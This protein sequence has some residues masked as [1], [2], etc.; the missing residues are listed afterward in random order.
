MKG[1]VVLVLAPHTDDGELGCGGTITKL[2]ED[3]NKV[4]YAAFSTAEESVPEGI[5][6][7][8]LKDEVKEATNALGIK[9]ENIILFNYQVRR[10]N[11]LR[12]NILED[13]ISLKKSI[14]PN[15]V[16]I[17]SM[18]DIHQDHSVVSDEGIRAFKNC[19]VL[20]YELPWNNSVFKT[21]AFVKLEKKHIVTKIKSLQ[22]YNSQ[23]IRPYMDENFINSLAQVRGLQ[24]GCKFAE[25]FEVIRWII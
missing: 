11:E 18:H 2:I 13:I 6:K 22:Y 10:F 14:E 12:Q 9:S 16:F 21:Q 19:T 3:G 5:K 15:I 20:G 4:Y 1:K 24:V 23:S 7:D 8:I 17:P 25:A